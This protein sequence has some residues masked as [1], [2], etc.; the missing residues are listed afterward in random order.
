MAKGINGTQGYAEQAKQLLVDYEKISFED[1]HSD[2]LQLIPGAP[3]IVLDIGSGTGRDAAYFAKMGH[4][5]VAVEPTDELRGPASRMH[6]SPSIDWVDDGL[7]DLRRTVARG[8]LFDLA[9]LSAVWMHLDAAERQCAMPVL[10]SLVRPGG[11]II[12]T[13]RHG[14]V[15]S[16]R[17][18]FD[19]TAD[20]TIGLAQPEHLSPMM[21]LH[22]KSI[23]GVNKR[24]GVT[25]T[26]IA[27]KKDVEADA[28]G[29]GP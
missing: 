1:V 9:M 15:P 26:R 3:S 21:N 13:L 23:Q 16:G 6:P 12:M 20:E 7:P 4:R 22:T 28:D 8:E 17:R 24:A 10:A 14:P 19:V 2:V 27:F 18:M 11:V 29:A 5:V 25:W